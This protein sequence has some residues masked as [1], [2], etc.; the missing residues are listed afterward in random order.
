[1]QH[2]QQPKSKM[3]TIKNGPI[4]FFV[5]NLGRENLD[6]FVKKQRTP[7]ALH[8][9]KKFAIAAAI[10]FSVLGTTVA[11]DAIAGHHV[12]ASL[13]ASKDIEKD[14]TDIEGIGE[15]AIDVSLF[16]GAAEVMFMYWQARDA[17]VAQLPTVIPEL[18]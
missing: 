4:H 9:G 18:V 12:Y 15:I 6:D 1:M 8:A 5:R 2:W 13:S 7:E 17:Q 16:W 3:A 14:T 11:F 10:G